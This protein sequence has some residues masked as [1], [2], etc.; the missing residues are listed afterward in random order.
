MLYERGNQ[1]GEKEK[2]MNYV[3]VCPPKC[4]N[5]SPTC[6]ATCETYLE[7]YRNNVEKYKKNLIRCFVRELN[8]DGVMKG[9]GR[10]K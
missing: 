7:S 1:D 8:V 3:T 4:Q 5:R 10:A 2:A 6:H 9:K